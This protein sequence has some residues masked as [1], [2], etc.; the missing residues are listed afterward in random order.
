MAI[1]VLIYRNPSWHG[2]SGSAKKLLSKRYHISGAER[3]VNFFLGGGHHSVSVPT[4]RLAGW[5]G[6]TS[7]KR[8]RRAKLG[9]VG[10]VFFT[11]KT[12]IL[13]F[14][15]KTTIYIVLSS[16]GTTSATT[17]PPR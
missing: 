12:K 6:A 11:Y 2:H 10:G 15:Y 8:L 3:I 9:W 7:R 4:F 17:A 5:M 16:S 14:T 13:F 1:V